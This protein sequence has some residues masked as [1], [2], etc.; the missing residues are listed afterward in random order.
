MT[1][2]SSSSFFRVKSH[3]EQDI[4]NYS[5]AG[6]YGLVALVALVQLVR[7]QLRVPEYGWTTQKVFHFLNFLQS[8]FR[9]AVF[10]LLRAIAKTPKVLQFVL[11]DTPGL[12]YFSTYTLLILFWAE[13]Y[14]QARSLP[15]T[16]LRPIFVVINVLVYAVQIGIW[17]WLA[18]PS[19]KHFQDQYP[20]CQCFLAGVFI[21]AALGFFVHGGRLFL[22]L[23]R[24]PVESRGRT[25]KLREVGCVTVI[26]SLC[27]TGRA[28][29]IIYDAVAGNRLDLDTIDHPITDAIYYGVFEVLP[30]ALVL[31]ILRKLPPRKQTGYQPLPAQ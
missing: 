25:K 20:Y 30:S 24:F 17:I 23:R 3:Q 16:Y 8:S 9:A 11:V 14:H 1:N 19:Q 10:I 12:L 6:A 29:F 2:D 27:F 22:M 28:A 13:I 18:I 5:L 4:I 7:I 26:C 21:L 15:T 31:L